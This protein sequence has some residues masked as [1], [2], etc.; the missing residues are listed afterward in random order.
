MLTDDGRAGGVVGLLFGLFNAFL[1]GT[2][3][4]RGPLV[5]A[6]ALVLHQTLYGLLVLLVLDG[7]N[8]VADGLLKLRHRL[9]RALLR[10]LQTRV[11]ATKIPSR[12]TVT[13]E[14]TIFNRQSELSY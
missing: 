12:L 9:L 1:I 11:R 4:R 2:T 7:P 6:R 14:R 13:L 8:R 3:L 5:V 10:R